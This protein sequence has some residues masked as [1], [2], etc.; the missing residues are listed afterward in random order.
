MQIGKCTATAAAA[1][2]LAHT[3]VLADKRPLLLFVLDA[4]PSSISHSMR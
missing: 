1:A 4:T 2:D 3:T